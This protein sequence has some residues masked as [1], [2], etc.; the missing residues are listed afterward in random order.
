M[1]NVRYERRGGGG[2]EN[3]MSCHINAY[4]GL[5]G[6][7]FDLN[8]FLKQDNQERRKRHWYVLLIIVT[9]QENAKD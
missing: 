3:L 4:N 8:Y 2:G 6:K 9:E 7:L 5:G 1:S